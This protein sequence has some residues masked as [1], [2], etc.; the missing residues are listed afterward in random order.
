VLASVLPAP[1]SPETTTLALQQIGL[2][3][4]LVLGLRLGLGLGLEPGLGP[5]LGLGLGI[6]LTCSAAAARCGGRAR[7][8]HRGAADARRAAPPSA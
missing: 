1:L 7:R 6:G 4:G 8:L 2:G 3:L 5:G